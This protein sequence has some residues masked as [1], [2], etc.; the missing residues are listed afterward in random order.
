MD[1][2]DLARIVVLMASLPGRAQP[3]GSADPA[4]RHAL[5]RPRLTT[6]PP[7]AVFGWPRI[8][9]PLRCSVPCGGKIRSGTP[10]HA[11]HRPARRRSLFAVVSA[12]GPASTAEAPTAALEKSFDAQIDPAEIGTWLKLLAAEP[13][14]VG[15]PHDKANAEWILAQFKSWGWDAHIETFDVLYPTP[16]SEALELPG[17]AAFKATL[18]R[19]AA[20]GDHLDA[21]AKDALPAYVAFQGDGDVTAPLV[22]V[23][24]G[25]PEDYMALE[26]MG[27][28]VK[29][30]IVIARYGGGWRGLKPLL[31]QMHGAVG[32]M[33]ASASRHS[34]TIVTGPAGR[35]L[36][37]RDRPWSRVTTSVR[38][39]S[40]VAVVPSVAALPPS[41]VRVQRMPP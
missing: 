22:Y 15:S 19:A 26:R 9:C 18:H 1:P 11:S 17:P 28:G 40:E 12:T 16:M 7:A 8:S 36:R 20:P 25:M 21:T 33:S 31:A 37:Q 41:L 4:A 3:A 39:R 34:A 27:I 38:S 32:C 30:K 13:N 23:N 35:E 14:Q 24:Y 6:Q 5:P 2:H 10:P 29:G